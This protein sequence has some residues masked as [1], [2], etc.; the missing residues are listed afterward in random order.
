MNCKPDYLCKLSDICLRIANIVDRQGENGSFSLA[1]ELGFG[2]LALSGYLRSGVK[3]IADMQM[4]YS[5]AKSQK[6]LAEIG[7]QEMRDF[8]T[9]IFG[10]E[11][12]ESINEADKE[13]IRQFVQELEKEWERSSKC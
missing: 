8:L 10:D 3:A 5:N 13:K 11:E 2:Y 7:E 6:Q 12:I 4:D 9:D 1:D